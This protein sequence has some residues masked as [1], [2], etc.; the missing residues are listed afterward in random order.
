MVA[1]RC[2]DEGIDVPA[3]RMAFLL[4]SARNPRQFVQRRGRILRRAPGK[5]A[6]E[7]FDFPVRI[8]PVLCEGHEY[9]RSL[10][11]SELR[12]IAEFATMALN[13]GEC[14]ERLRPVLRE[15]DLEHLLS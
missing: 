5:E 10:L 6:A 13:R 1:I 12:R 11:V 3:C 8:P 2:L 7:I 9:E 4:A 14:Y 15:Y